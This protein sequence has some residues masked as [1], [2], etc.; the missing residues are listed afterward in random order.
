MN[1]KIS[2]D[3]LLN[4]LTIVQKALPQKTPL[5]ILYTIKI[6]A[7]E[8]YLL[9]TATNSDIAIEVSVNK[10]INVKNTGSFC[11]SGKYLIE[12][13][14][15]IDQGEIEFLQLDE[16]NVVIKTQRSS[17]KLK[18]WDSSE[19]V[20]INYVIQKN[21]INISNETFREILDQTLYAVSND[22]K[23]TIFKGVQFLSK[24]NTLAISATDTYRLSR[25][26]IQINTEKDF[27]IIIPGQ[28]L[29]ELLKIIEIKETDIKLFISDYNNKALFILDNISFQTR[30]IE[31][32]YPDISKLIIDNSQLE[33]PFNKNELLIAADRV[34]ILSTKEKNDNT[35]INLTLRKD[36]IVEISSRNE[37]IGA[38]QEL[39]YVYGQ[40]KGDIDSFKL[41][42]N[43]KYLIEA[44]KTYNSSDV[45]IKFTSETKQFSIY[46]EE[47]KDLLAIILPV[48]LNQ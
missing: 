44:L 16:S 21:E 38:A 10:E 37:E 11:I 35:Y 46:G 41:T 48:K 36:N 34:S 7:Y 3:E 18:V 31:G 23:K 39:I 12:I 8:Q 30:L 19:Y 28:S 20:D 24:D 27:D 14:K 4:T 32:R 22:D 29:K 26:V 42:F 33:I 9:F 5:P 2:R 25:K 17:F 45:V 6:D 15:K 43:S 40:I 13:I 1:F 47:D